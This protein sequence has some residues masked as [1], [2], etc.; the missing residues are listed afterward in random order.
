MNNSNIFFFPRFFRKGLWLLCFLLAVGSAHADSSY[1]TWKNGPAKD[2]TFFPIAVWLQ[3][4]LNAPKFKA[5]GFNLYVGLWEGPTEDQLATLNKYGMKV[6]CGQNQV[7]LSHLDD[8]TIVG[9]MHDDETD[10][11]QPLPGKDA[12]YG[13]PTLPGQIEREYHKFHK[14][15]PTRPVL[16]NLGQGVAWDDWFG[17][18]VRTHHP[19]DYHEYIKGCDIASFDIYPVVHDSPAVKGNLWYV[20]RGV[21]RL[22]QWSKPGQIVWNAIECTHIGNPV[23]KPTPQEVKA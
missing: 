15:D 3:N 9:W 16:L 12:G 6:I 1:S 18:G 8:P 22:K 14:A 23:T 11:A 2:D 7:G 20:P 13:P 17:R 10:N 5:A 21:D 19:E 4:P